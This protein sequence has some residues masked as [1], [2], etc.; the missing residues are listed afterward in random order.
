MSLSQL[1]VIFANFRQFSAKI[2]K[3][4]CHDQIFA[5]TSSNFRKRQ[6]FAD[7]FGKTIFKIIE[8][9]PDNGSLHH[10]RS[11]SALRAEHLTV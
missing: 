10:L 9:V 6:F 3:K 8:S 11:S 4:Q 5:K 1:S 2:K 7:F